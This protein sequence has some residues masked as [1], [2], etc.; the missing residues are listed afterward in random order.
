MVVHVVSITKLTLFF[1]IVPAKA[2]L[3]LDRIWSCV[4]ARFCFVLG[5]LVLEVLVFVL[6]KLVLGI[7]VTLRLISIVQ[8][9]GNENQRFL[10]F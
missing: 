5:E 7:L 10:V 2:E 8:G 9:N 4:C 1:G 3:C 6:G